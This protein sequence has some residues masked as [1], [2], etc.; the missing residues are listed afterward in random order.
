LYVVCPEHLDEAID[1]FVE[2]YGTSPDVYLLEKTNFTDWTPP[3][4]CQYCGQ[5]P[6]YLVI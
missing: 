4:N 6:V 2:E 1:A 5:G 3:E